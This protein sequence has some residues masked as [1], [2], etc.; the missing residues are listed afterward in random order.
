MKDLFSFDRFL[1][2]IPQILPYLSVTFGLVL[3]ATL[4]GSVL[5]FFIALIRLKRTPVLF[6]VCSVYISFMR[7]TPMLVQLFLIL[8]GLPLLLNPILGINI[9]REWDVIY[10]GAITFILNQGAFLSSIFYAAIKAVPKGQFEAGYSVGLTTAQNYRRIILPQAVRTALPPFGVDL[11][12]LF[13]NVSLVFAIGV[14][15]IMGRARSIG[16]ATTHALEAYLFVA[17][18]YIIISLGVRF[19]FAKLDRKLSYG[20]A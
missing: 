11:V 5:A 15:D 4:L 20:R 12:G 16:A 14:I 3:A 18:L 9:A 8:Y 6:Q 7:G 1:S 17:L 13:Q 19:L 2:A 10:F